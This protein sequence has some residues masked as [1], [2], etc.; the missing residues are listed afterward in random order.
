MSAPPG[1]SF[2]FPSRTSMYWETCH[3]TYDQAVE[4]FNARTATQQA[5]GQNPIVSSTKIKRV[6]YSSIQDAQEEYS[7]QTIEKSLDFEKRI[8]EVKETGNQ[9]AKNLVDHINSYDGPTFDGIKGSDE[10]K[11]KS[12]GDDADIYTDDKDH[13]VVFLGGAGMRGEYQY[14]MVRALKN[15]GVKRAFCGNYSGLFENGND[16]DY[17]ANIDMGADA[18]SV[19]FYNQAEDDPIALHMVNSSECTIESKYELGRA[20]LVRYSG[21]NANGDDCPSSVFRVKVSPSTLDLSLPSLGVTASLPKQGGE[22]TFIGYSWGG[23]ISARAAIF[24]ANKGITVD[25]LVLIGA[26]INYSLVQAVK[27]H[28]NIKNVIIMDL[29]EQGDPIYA[30]ISDGELIKIS[31][32]LASQMLDGDGHFYYSGDDEVGQKRREEL[33]KQLV[34]QGIK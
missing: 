7:K 10:T 29:K 15:S 25:N 19:I 28:E 14:D 32:L 9:S 12:V 27:S 26:P 18:T 17:N 34:A 3:V 5:M 24:H 20:E 11:T 2:P 23:V 13:L 1:R 22:F 21:K 4:M 16:L 8:L 33:A 6:K 30:G 31:Y